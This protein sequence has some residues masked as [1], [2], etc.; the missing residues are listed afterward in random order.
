MRKI[1]LSTLFT[2]SIA[3]A[4]G[5]RD[6]M[7]MDYNQPQAQANYI[8]LRVVESLPQYENISVKVPVEECREER[9]SGGSRGA[10]IVGTIAGGVAGG[11]IGNNFV[12]GKNKKAATVGLGI[13]GAIIGNGIGS[14]GEDDERTEMRCGTHYR[15]TIERRVVGYKNIALLNNHEIVQYSAAPLNYIRIKPRGM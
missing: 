1:I 12:K 6:Y 2:V 3:F 15:E 9:T 10:S 4:G 13:V 11:A 7:P 14:T 5:I 8:D